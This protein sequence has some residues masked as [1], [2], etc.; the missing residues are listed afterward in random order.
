MTGIR[1]YHAPLVAGIVL[2]VLFNAWLFTT[3]R[4][5]LP[6]GE[7]ADWS[8]FVEAGRRIESGGSVYAV[9]ADYAFRYSPLLAYLFAV[10]APIGVLAWRLLHVVALGA[11]VATDR[12]LWPVA[13][14]ALVSWP[15][16]FDVEA[17]NLITFVLVT[18]ALALRG[19]PLGIGAF[20]TLSLL[21]PRPLMLPLLGWILWRHPNWR[22]PFAGMAVAVGMLTL[23]TGLAGT[24]LVALLAS[25]D[26]IASVLNFGPSRLIGLAWIPVGLAAAAV[27]TWR[28]RLGLASL[29]A[30][31]YWFPYYFLV[32]VWEAARPFVPGRIDRARPDS[33]A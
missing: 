17:G 22:L 9:E 3:T 28:G 4:W 21:V 7:A 15:F 1:L 6:A 13:V 23:L 29:A 24:W 30:S 20:L 33:G 32:L 18:G 14:L 10:L 12:R 31:P 11:M 8:S 25:T 26:E 27:L 2:V 19:N 5:H 16:W